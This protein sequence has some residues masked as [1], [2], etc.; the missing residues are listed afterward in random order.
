[1]ARAVTADPDREGGRR[2]AAAAPASHDWMIGRG[3]VWFGVWQQPP[4]PSVVFRFVEVALMEF[5]GR[6]D[7]DGRPMIRIVLRSGV[8]VIGSAFERC[9]HPPDIADSMDVD[10]VT[11]PALPSGGRRR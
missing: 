8:Q 10:A 6:S 1:M 4:H 7:L 2:A 5:I 11:R 3:Y 9:E